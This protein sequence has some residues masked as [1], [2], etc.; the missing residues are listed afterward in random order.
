LSVDSGHLRSGE[1][2][3]DSRPNYQEFLILAEKVVQLEDR[4]A[5]IDLVDLAAIYQRL[6][7][8]GGALDALE[9]SAER[10]SDGQSE[11]LSRLSGDIEEIRREARALREGIDASADKVSDGQ[12]ELSRLSRDIEEIRRETRAL[13]EGIEA[14]LHDMERRLEAQEEQLSSRRSRSSLFREALARWRT[15]GNVERRS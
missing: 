5:A 11:L 12:A 8:S 10:T 9:M 6:E 15:S 1:S 4:V 2:D 14:R 3:F 7:E 13:R